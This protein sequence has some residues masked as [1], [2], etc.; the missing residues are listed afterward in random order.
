MA[1]TQSALAHAVARDFLRAAPPE[2]GIKRLWVWS[3]H[4]YIDPERDYVE[5]TVFVDPARPGSDGGLDAAAA[6]LQAQFTDVDLILHTFSDL[7]IGTLDPAGEARED[8][9]EIG[10]GAR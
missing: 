1:I 10:L 3:Q 6:S 2:A 5:L 8:A 4:G 7:D 9:E